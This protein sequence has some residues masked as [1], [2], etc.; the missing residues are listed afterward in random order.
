[1]QFISRQCVS[2]VVA[3]VAVVAVDVFCCGF[4]RTQVIRLLEEKQRTRSMNG[5][6]IIAQSHPTAQII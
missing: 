4:P 2:G 1:M 5:K 6:H 3:A